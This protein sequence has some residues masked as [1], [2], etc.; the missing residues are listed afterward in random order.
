MKKWINGKIVEMT[1]EEVAAME[2]ETAQP[3]IEQ[4]AELTTEER[5][6]NLE[7]ALN[8]ILNGVTE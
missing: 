3:E 2:A 7:E 5:I 1:A 4:H 6:A 8:M